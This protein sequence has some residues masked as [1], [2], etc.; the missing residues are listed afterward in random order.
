LISKI[1]IFRLKKAGAKKMGKLKAY[2]AYDF[3]CN[4]SLGEMLSVFNDAG[5]WQWELRESSWYGDYLNAQLVERVR[6]RIHEYPQTGEAGEFVGLRDKGFSA[7]LEIESESS[8]TREEIEEAFGA[9]LEK[10]GA[11]DVKEIEPYD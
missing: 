9:L 4:R 3:G 1:S 6:V 8:A 11:E 2:W 5:P 7:L 10:I